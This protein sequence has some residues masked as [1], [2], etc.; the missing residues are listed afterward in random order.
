MCG[1]VGVA[2]LKSLDKDCKTFFQQALYADMLRGEDSTGLC[3]V[4]RKKHRDIFKRAMAAYDFLEMKQADRLLDKFWD[5]KI[6]IGHNRYATKGGIS[7]RS[8]HPFSEEN[9]TLV[10]NGTLRTM[11]QLPDAKDYAVDSELICH[12]IVVDGVQ[13]T[14]ENLNGAF[15]LVWYD[16]DKDTLNFIRNEERPLS[17]GYNIKNDVLMWASEIGMLRWLAT[18]NGLFLDQVSQLDSMNH[19]EFDMSG[20]VIFKPEV[21]IYKEYEIKKTITPT[22]VSNMGGGTGTMTTTHSTR[23]YNYGRP[24]PDFFPKITEEIEVYFQTCTKS[25]NKL[26]VWKGISMEKDLYEF[27]TAYNMPKG[28]FKEGLYKATVFNVVDSALEKDFLMYVGNVEYIGDIEQSIVYQE[29]DDSNGNVIETT[30]K[31]II[32]FEEVRDEPLF[33]GPGGRYLSAWEFDMAVRDGCSKCTRD[34]YVHD[35]DDVMWLDLKTPICQKCQDEME[36]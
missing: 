4:G 11:Y 15:A 12:S 13:K 23:R 8:A 25:P 36:E 32:P 6:A 7:H 9:I 22:G 19:Q 17:V 21:T 3:L 16:A 5:S 30:T 14:I 20:K 26:E 35:A 18:R 34:I 24:I 1:I 2:S 28:T 31:D 29:E 10:H 33:K 27:A